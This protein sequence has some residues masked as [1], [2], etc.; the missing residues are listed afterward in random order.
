MRSIGNEL[1]KLYAK[2][3]LGIGLTA[4]PLR[5]SMVGDTKTPLIVLLASAALVL[6]ITCANLA[7]AML[8]RTISRRK[9][10]AVRVALGAGRGRLVRQL[11]TE[12][13]MLSVI[14]AIAGVLLAI[15]MLGVLR[16]LSLSVIPTYADLTLDTGAVVVTFALA[17][18][19]GVAFGIGPAMSVG[20]ADPQAT[21][22]DETRGSTES[23]RSRR[24][25]GVLVAGQI[26]LCASLLAAA[27]LLAKSLWQISNAPL[28]FK[29]DHLLTFSV[30]LPNSRYGRLQ[31]REAYHDEMEKRLR[32]LP[33]VTAVGT[34]RDL[35][36]T[37][38]NSNGIFIQSRPWAA[39]E[40]VPF[41]TTSVASE[42]YFKAMGIPLLKGRF[43][44]TADAFRKEG[45]SVM[46]I[47]E[48]FAKK[49]FPHA[50]PLGAQI[51][52]GPPGS[53]PWATVVG[54]IGDIRNKPLALTPDPMMFFPLRQN[55]VGETVVIRTTGDPEAL[56]PTVRNI[57]KSMDASVPITRMSTVEEVISKGFA[58]QRLPVLLMGGF[59]VLALLLASVG[60]YA[61]FTSMATA[62]EREFGVRIALGGS[63]GSVAGLVLRQGGVWMGIGLAIG[64]IG[65]V[66]AARLVKSQLYGVPEFDP[67]TIAGALLVLL[68]CAGVALLVPVRRATRVDPI[69]VLR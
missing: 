31:P 62:R 56:I 39:N 27:G 45:P 20:R 47:T 10:F 52:W 42:D 25:R 50:D 55:P 65:I 66:I 21:L 1:E 16:G 22:R 34:T 15:A 48:A 41:I 68:A 2:D 57:I 37:I 9:E 63:R 49:Y 40:P 6:L 43:F 11:L 59:G 46:L 8:S 53:S 58:A 24:M 30:Q 54:V 3:N 35:P 44:T 28:G 23:V 5:D 32:A 29:T 67:Y 33:G 7:G 4:V 26:A 38:G 64:A 14:G 13:V 60:V 18:L 12:S 51:A 69:S 61:M 19:T 17:L 36:T